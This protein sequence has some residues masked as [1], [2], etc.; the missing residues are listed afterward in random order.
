M[1]YRNEII[2]AIHLGLRRGYNRKL[3]FRNKWTAFEGKMTEYLLTVSVANELHDLR[4]YGKNTAIELEYPLYQ[5]YNN[6]FPEAIWTNQDDLFA[7][8]EYLCREYSAEATKERMDITVM[9]EERINFSKN[10]RSL[11]GIEIKAINTG[12]GG[13]LKDIERLAQSMIENQDVT[14]ENSI[15]S[16][17]SAF[18]KSYSNGTRPTLR[19][20]I[21]HKK[22][23][24]QNQLD[25]RLSNQ[26]RNNQAYKDLEFN[27]IPK[28][29]DCTPFEDY[30]E[31]NKH[32]PDFELGWDP[33]SETGSIL[34]VVIEIIRKQ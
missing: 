25:A 10:Y 6:A 3:E 9:F 27:I 8:H 21:D 1:T 28:D 34:G 16:C 24:I 7:E 33:D 30:Y 20:E 23:E 18:V 15:A 2:E 13:V 29:I 22:Q 19:A 14:G 17:Y 12:Y 26:I 4:T 5:F 31:Q 32:I 11:H